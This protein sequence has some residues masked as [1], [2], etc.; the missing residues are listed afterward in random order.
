MTGAASRSLLGGSQVIGG[1]VPGLLGPLSG[2]RSVYAAWSE[3][4]RC[5]TR[6]GGEHRAQS[7]LSEAQARTVDTR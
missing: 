4:F 7:R 3:R 1:S 6:H 5:L 2:T